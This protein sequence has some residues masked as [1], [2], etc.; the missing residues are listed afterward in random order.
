MKLR[1]AHHLSAMLL[2]LSIALTESNGNQAGL[3]FWHTSPAVTWNDT[4]PLGNDH[5]GAMVLDGIEKDG[6]INFTY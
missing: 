1:P 6:Q 5:P 4:L 3:K 2:L